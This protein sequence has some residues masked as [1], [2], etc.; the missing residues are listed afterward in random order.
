MRIIAYVLSTALGLAA[1]LAA[2]QT[3]PELGVAGASVVPVLAALVALWAVGLFSGV[4]SGGSLRDPATDDGRRARRTFIVAA[5]AVAVAAAAL[6]LVLAATGN[7][8]LGASAVALVVAAAYIAANVFAGRA[9]RARADRR[10]VGPFPIPP[11]TPDYSHRRAYSAVVVATSVLTA[12]V[13][14]ALT[15]GR[16]ALETS[17]SPLRTIALAL[18][19]AAITAT[20]LC[21]ISVVTL[22][23]RVRDLNGTDAARL[24]RIRRVVLRGKPIP[25][26]EEETAIAAAY[27]P[28]AAQS[29]RW[30]IAQSVTV[31]VGVLCV[32]EPTPD[33]PIAVMIWILFPVL[34]AVAVPLSLRSARRAERYALEHRERASGNGSATVGN[35]PTTPAHT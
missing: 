15:T 31:T 26:T 23:G 33:R 32:N 17:P 5:G 28:Y 12:G 1:L 14:V 35:T 24:K 30:S 10:R 20:V 9:L 34:L 27:A 16:P 25:L 11:F 6:I 18:S 8:P 21:A 4:V 13:L 19:F 29:Q 7:A 22:S 3:V 2:S